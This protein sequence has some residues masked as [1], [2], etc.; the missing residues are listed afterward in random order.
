[1]PLRHGKNYYVWGNSRKKY[2]YANEADR[3]KAKRR[4]II[5]GYAIEKSEEREGKKSSLTRSKS[6][7][8]KTHLKGIA[9]Q[10]STITKSYSGSKTRKSSSG[11]KARKPSS[12]SKTRKSIT[13]PIKRN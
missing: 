4:A 6:T 2:Y 12:G 1:M 10:K 9:G 11:S 13:R 5:Q 7:G 8:R 3:K